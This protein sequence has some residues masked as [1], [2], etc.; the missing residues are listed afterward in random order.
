M[1]LLSSIHRNHIVLNCRCGHV[2]I[3]SVTDLIEVYGPETTLDAVERAARCTRCRCKS[4]TSTQIIYVGNS[5]IALRGTAV[6]A[7]PTDQ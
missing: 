7:K 6:K 2:G 4:I 5:D 1:I 3:I